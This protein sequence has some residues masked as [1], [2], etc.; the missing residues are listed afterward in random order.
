MAQAPHPA[1]LLRDGDAWRLGAALAA[2]KTAEE[3]REEASD[4]LNTAEELLAF[5]RQ[6][7]RAM[8][9]EC[10]RLGIAS[11]DPEFVEAFERIC[12]PGLCDDCDDEARGL[13]GL[14]DRVR[15]FTTT[16]AAEGAAEMR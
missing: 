5:E 12:G 1:F 4:R 6:R 14:E 9:A 10:A 13:C 3:R 11:D 16:G 15:G 8:A 7:L 2:V